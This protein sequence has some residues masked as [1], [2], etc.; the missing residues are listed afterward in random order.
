M[1]AKFF[2]QKLF[3]TEHFREI[4]KGTLPWEAAWA[5]VSGFVKVCGYLDSVYRLIALN[6]KNIRWNK[7]IWIPF[8]KLSRLRLLSYLH[9]PENKLRSHKRFQIQTFRI[10][11]LS[12]TLLAHLYCTL[13]DEIFKQVKTKANIIQH[14]AQTRPTCYIQQFWMMLAQHVGFVWEGL[15]CKW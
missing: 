10:H 4:E 5:K 14:G 2:C 6:F 13:L 8:E 3:L 11:A 15:E 7:L 12:A 1:K 9:L